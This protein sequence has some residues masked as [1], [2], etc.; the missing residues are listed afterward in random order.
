M[1]RQ[2][3]CPAG[4]LS[5]MDRGSE[6]PTSPGSGV[7]KPHLAS[8]ILACAMAETLAKLGAGIT[9]PAL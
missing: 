9:F 2:I 1:Q 5:R 3:G 4:D 7:A 8:V 6:Q